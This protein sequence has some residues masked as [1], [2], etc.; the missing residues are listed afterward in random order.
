MESQLLIQPKTLHIKV[1][2]GRTHTSRS[3]RES[4][5][6]V[7]NR[8]NFWSS[9]TGLPSKYEWMEDV[10]NIISKQIPENKLSLSVVRYVEL[11]LEKFADNYLS[12]VQVTGFAE[13]DFGNE[14]LFNWFGFSP[15]NIED[16]KDLAELRDCLQKCFDDNLD[17]LLEDNSDIT[18]LFI[19]ISST[20]IIK[21]LIVSLEY[22]LDDIPNPEEL[23]LF[24]V[25]H[26]AEYDARFSIFRLEEYME[27]DILPENPSNDG[28][29]IGILRLN[30]ADFIRKNYNMNPL[31][32]AGSIELLAGTSNIIVINHKSDKLVADIIDKLIQP[33][34]TLDLT[35]FLNLHRYIL[36]LVFEEI[37]VILTKT[38]TTQWT[39]AVVIDAINSAA[40]K[41]RQ[42]IS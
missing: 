32:E 4:L 14:T 9:L 1:P 23:T 31:L 36:Y 15:E 28:L 11:C 40:K 8:V 22:M 13:E 25:M 17:E 35:I 18:D 29:T 42:N 5:S 39:N 34:S 41:F 24:F 27:P 6:P 19:N 38:K 7:G 26:T 21:F 3:T 20:L 2:R 37:Q 16:D 10:F 33:A 30:L 12:Q